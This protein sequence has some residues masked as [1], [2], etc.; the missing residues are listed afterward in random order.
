MWIAITSGIGTY[1]AA[2]RTAIEDL[3]KHAATVIL[4]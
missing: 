3:Y 4:L 2:C 1:Q